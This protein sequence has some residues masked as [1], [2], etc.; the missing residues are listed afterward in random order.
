MTDKYIAILQTGQPI[1]PARDI[2]GDFDE[3]FIK[4]MEIDASQTKTFH[5]Y[6]N[7]TLPNPNQLMG[8]LITGS[9][10]MVTEGNEW[11]IKTQ[12]WLKQFIDTNIPIIGVCY[13]HQL[14]A[15][16]LGGRVSWNPR[17][18]EMGQIEMEFTENAYQDRLF[19]KIINRSIKNIK[20]QATHQQAVLELPPVAK[21]LGFTN[22]DNNHCFCAHNHIW[23]LQFHPEFTP[24][25][26][27]NYISIRQQ[28]IKK[29]GLEPKT[30]LAEIEDIN[31]GNEILI[32][33]KKLCLDYA[34]K[35]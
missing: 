12:N 13:G 31:N 25:I 1:Q 6:E 2:Y 23:G 10:A 27:A 30:M 19:S 18:R 3:L 26:I 22:L 15:M 16:M 24:E 11:C 5:I 14:L 7:P 28:D 17:G 35:A 32:H 20:L 34:R 4:S 29:E 21:R 33:F 9:P 8:I